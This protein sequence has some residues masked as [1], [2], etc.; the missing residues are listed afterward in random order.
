MSLIVVKHVPNS[1]PTLS[2][3]LT[4]MRVIDSHH[5]KYTKDTTFNYRDMNTA[6]SEGYS[7]VVIPED[8]HN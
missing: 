4:E 5:P 6:V 1:V 7:V 8:K 3:R 2:N